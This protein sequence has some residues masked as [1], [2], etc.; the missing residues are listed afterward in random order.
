MPGNTHFWTVN[1]NERD[2]M[3][4]SGYSYEGV[5]MR[6]PS[7][8]S[9][10]KPVYR[11]YSPVIQRHLYTNDWNEVATLARLGDWNYEGVAWYGALS[12]TPVYRIYSPV[13]YEHLYTTDKYE[14]D[15]WVSRG[16]FIDD[17]IGWYQP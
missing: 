3:I 16:L 1:I 7:G 4:Q 14:R 9:I 11:M 2:R 6:V 13:T 15:F 12:G 5:A 8:T 10:G 17:G